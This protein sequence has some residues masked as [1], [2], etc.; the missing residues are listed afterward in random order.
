[1]G[2]RPILDGLYIIPGL[3]NIYLLDTPDGCVA[4][5]TG[6]PGSL[7]KILDGMHSIGKRPTDL[8]HILLTHG[9]PDHI[10]GA[11]ALKRATGA[12][13]YAH[14]ADARIIEAGTGFRPV[15]PSP[16]LRNR[17]VFELILK[18]VKKV[19]PT[20]VDVLID[21][22]KNLEFAGDLMPIHIPG[23]C[24]GQLA[25]LWA[26]NGGVLFTADACINRGGRMQLTAATEDIE[27]A[28]RSLAK[29]AGYQFEIA[30]FGH[31][32]PITENANSDFRRKWVS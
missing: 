16:G 23:H 2:I 11:A 15:F 25:F 4:V 22:G 5:D 10:G 27:E 6:F 18:R 12:T 29:L 13:V 28:R 32:P 30:C 21:E 26:R 17:L 14:A 3:V 8:R 19:E 20:K 7:K 24:F 9:H 1:M 31:G